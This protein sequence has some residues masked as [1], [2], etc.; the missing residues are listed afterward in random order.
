MALVT[1][2]GTEL[3]RRLNVFFRLRS[4][5]FEGPAIVKPPALPEDTYFLFIRFLRTSKIFFILE[6][7]SVQYLLGNALFQAVLINVVY[8]TLEKF[9]I[10][11]QLDF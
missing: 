5:P 9:T 8:S 10:N 7:E 11:D 1:T 4:G 3:S 6:G 2:T